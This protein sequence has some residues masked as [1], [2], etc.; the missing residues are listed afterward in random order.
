MS[1]VCGTI[2]FTRATAWG[3]AGR[4]APQASA[5]ASRRNHLRMHHC[6]KLTKIKLLGLAPDDMAVVTGG[7]ILRL[8]G[9]APRLGGPRPA[10]SVLGPPTIE[11]G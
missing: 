5:A 11:D 3:R 8:I 1:G 9:R 10:S 4:R 7:N 6:L 2:R